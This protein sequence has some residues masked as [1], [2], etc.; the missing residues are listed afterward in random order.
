MDTRSLS[1]ARKAG[2]KRVLARSPLR[3]EADHGVCQACLGRKASGGDWDIGTN[4]G[5][6]ASQSVGEPSTQLSLNVF[7]TGG[8]AKGRG[9]KSKG[10]FKRL[11]QI[12][13][14]PQNL[15]NSAPLSLVSGTVQ[16]VETAAQGGKNVYI[17]G[18]KH[19]VPSTQEVQ[20]KR[21]Q[22]VKR[23][24]SLSDGLVDP[25]KLLALRGIRDVQDHM[26]SELHGVL[27]T[28]APVRRRNVEVVIKAL[29]NVTKIEDP[30]AHPTWLPGDIRATSKVHAWNKRQKVK[31]R[32]SVEHAPILKGANILP[33]AMQEDWVARL[34]FNKLGTTL[35]EAAR[36]GWKS[37]IHGFHPVPALAY[38]KE[39]GKQVSVDQ[40]RGQY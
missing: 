16:K 27:K 8:I 34:N 9:A 14:L 12:I 28:V 11:E 39:F 30:K 7:H 6:I 36:E 18:K 31:G 2:R 33:L 24:Q 5:V 38:A 26:A 4:I 40:W 20:V 25:R 29:T 19:Y 17:G 21:G 10:T 3:C 1:A 37:N 13:R 35:I 15:P 22:A 32:K 23:G